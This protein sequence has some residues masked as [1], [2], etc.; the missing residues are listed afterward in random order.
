MRSA[1][2]PG[3]MGHEWVKRRFVARLG[4]SAGDRLFVPARLDDNP[5]INR[6]DYT[7]SLLN[8]DPVTRDR[9]LK[10]DWEARSLRGVLKR[11]WFEVVDAPPADLS[12]VRY[13][14][15]AYQKKK[16]SDF[17]VGV[18]YALARN[19]VSFILH[20]ARTQATPT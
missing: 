14:D 6:E 18:K 1:S 20:V 2:N 11:E 9:I 13:W 10:G 19:G 15:T 7:K 17:T 4:A 8:L 5:F 12:I 3:N 16:T